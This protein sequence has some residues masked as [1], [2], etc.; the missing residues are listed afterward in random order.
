MGLSMQ[1]YTAVVHQ[2][3]APYQAVFGEHLFSFLT[4]SY[5]WFGGINGTI[6]G[7]SNESAGRVEESLATT[8]PGSV[9]VFPRAV[10][11]PHTVWM[12]RE[13]SRG[14]RYSSWLNPDTDKFTESPETS[15][16][17][18]AKANRTGKKWWQYTGHHQ[19]PPGEKALRRSFQPSVVHL[20]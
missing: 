8:R 11:R 14:G 16:R 10:G 13:R 4:S 12:M 7:G 17:K 5:L 20:S 18:F 19:L 6:G 3:A 1:S 2:T 15:L 9:L